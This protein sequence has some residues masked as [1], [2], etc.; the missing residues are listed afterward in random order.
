MIVGHGDI[1]AALFENGKDRD[2]FCF[3]A[4][5]VSNS[6]ET[7]ESEFQREIDLLMS[8]DIGMHLVY[9]STLAIFYGSASPY[10][11]HKLFME[12]SVKAIFHFH[13]I[14]R[15]GNIAWGDTNPNTLINFIRNKIK[16][17][18]P[19][20]VQDVYRYILEKEEF[21]H[22]INLIPPW[23]VEMN[24]T[25]KRMLVKDI[26]KEYCYPWREFSGLA[27][28]NNSEQELSLCG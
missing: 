11:R 8:Q 14:I 17:R 1:A 26:V 15:I 24:L 3:F 16:A 19:F 5:G 13:T 25:G 9:F 27:K 21:L 20:E 2:D 18:E 7:R 12:S 28:R 4:S 23:P 10:I 6:A 22:W